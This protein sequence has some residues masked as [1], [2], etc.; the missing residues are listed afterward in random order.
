MT[1]TKRVEVTQAD[2]EAAAMVH[3]SAL[4]AETIRNGE[5]DGNHVVQAFAR[6]RLASQSLSTDEEVRRLRER[7]A[8]LE[9][10]RAA[11]KLNLLST[12]NDYGLLACP[13]CDSLHDPYPYWWQ[14]GQAWIIIC[15]NC[16]H[17]EGR[18]E[19]EG[20]ARNVWNKAAETARATALQSKDTPAH[21]G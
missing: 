10:E 15:G 13:K 8:E 18:E 12:T 17:E 1:E 2:R 3:A 11:W 14:R 9:A 5:I 7:V 6:H 16:K 21:G 20:L 4:L 19:Q